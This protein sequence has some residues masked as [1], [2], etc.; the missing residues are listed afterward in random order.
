M[1]IAKYVALTI[2]IIMLVGCEISPETDSRLEIP[3]AGDSGG[4][5]LED[6]AW[7]EVYFSAPDSTASSTLRGG[8]DAHLAEAID[9]ARLSVDLAADSLNLWSVRDA[10]LDAHRRGVAVRVVMESEN[11]DSEEVQE[12]IG[13]GVPLVDD[14]RQGLMHNKFVIIDR[15][16]VWSG[17]MNFTVSGAYRSDNNLIQIVSPALAENYLLEFEEMFSDHQFGADSPANTP[18]P[19]MEVEGIQVEVYFSPDDG[20]MLRILDLLGEARKS[21]YFMAYSFTDN[22]LARTMIALQDSGVQ[23]AGVMDEAQ[24]LSNTG[25]EFQ[26]LLANGVDVRL[27]GNP[28][29]M[30]HKV[31][32]IDGEIVVTGS[33][34]FSRS[35]RTR[36]D[37]N[38]LILHSQE[39][40]EIY[41]E[42]F[43]RVW[44]LAEKQ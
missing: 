11:L 44:Q 2:V 15:R 26:N 27:D 30:H 37:E 28:K 31:I 12:L 8:P 35:A 5:I 25:G 16:E 34:N 29:S 23:V 10:L 1:K 19:R 9:Q 36:N 21:V 39:I 20:T 33:Y 41:L 24:A 42:E 40:A 22:D 4:L 17:S 43:G 14:R 7:Y 13:G 38:T 3:E 18:L 32:I 6:P